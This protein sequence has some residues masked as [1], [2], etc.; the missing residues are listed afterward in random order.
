M[1]FG[2][3]EPAASDEQPLSDGSDSVD[4]QAPSPSEETDILPAVDASPSPPS[5]QPGP[6][7]E[8]YAALGRPARP[9]RR[10]RRMGLHPLLLVAMIGVVLLAAVLAAWMLLAG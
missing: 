8:D 6:T 5:A 10:R 7:A 2:R 4:L 3:E 9:A 1:P